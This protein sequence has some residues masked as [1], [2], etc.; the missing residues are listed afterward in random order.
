MTGGG[1]E[2]G[3]RDGA[4]WGVGVKV[5]S[6]REAAVLGEFSKRRVII[7]REMTGRKERKIH[8]D[9]LLTNDTSC[10]DALSRCD[11]TRCRKIK[12]LKIVALSRKP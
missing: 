10:G 11:L 3:V 7:L 6:G 9:P 2:W 5:G 1:A 12:G 8:F 4:G